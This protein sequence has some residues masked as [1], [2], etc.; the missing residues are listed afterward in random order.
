MKFILV[1]IVFSWLLNAR[2]ELCVDYFTGSPH[3]D[4]STY[5]EY[6]AGSNSSSRIQVVDFKN[7]SWIFEL[8]KS[9]WQ[10]IRPSQ[11]GRDVTLSNI[12]Q[13]GKSNKI[14][15]LVHEQESNLQGRRSVF[16]KTYLLE[17]NTMFK[18]AR[19]LAE[20]SNSIYSPEMTIP[21]KKDF[22]ILTGVTYNQGIRHD[23]FV[24]TTNSYFVDLNSGDY[25]SVYHSSS[26]S[27]QTRW[28]RQAIVGYTRV[29]TEISS[30]NVGSKNL[31]DGDVVWN[32][33]GEYVL[34]K[35][36]VNLVIS[37]FN[38]ETKKLETL[39]SINLLESEVPSEVLSHFGNIEI[40]RR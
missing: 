6:R 22:V 28:A 19:K 29:P 3:R 33:T 26:Y 9:A 36:G 23:V 2:S 31:Y 5:S 27:G 34:L 32:K 39:D 13:S 25:S 38:I 16:S 35:D 8:G 7:N 20:F 24:G 4:Y 15:L 1:F 21:W 11:R 14:Y 17:F 30:I 12:F 18:K 10:Y 37:Q 40:L